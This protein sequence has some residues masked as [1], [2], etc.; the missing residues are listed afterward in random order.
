MQARLDCHIAV[1]TKPPVAGEVKTRL[2]PTLG[3][4]GAAHLH[5]HMLRHTLSVVHNARA[6]SQSLWVA[7]DVSH[8]AVRAYAAQFQAS[9]HAQQGSDLG[10]R[11]ADAFDTLLRRHARVLLI[12]SDCPPLTPAHLRTAAEQ[13]DGGQGV[14]LIP[15]E[16]GGYVLLGLAA[17]PQICRKALLEALFHDISW[18]SADV[19]TQTRA[20]LAG[21]GFRWAELPSLWDLDRPEDLQRLAEFERLFLPEADTQ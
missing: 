21:C 8:P 15:A 14:V 20:H 7:G 6:V 11:M 5:D 10:E 16:D 1:F 18:S 9:L 2:I 3:A 19:L 4:E 17:T 12:G 13:L